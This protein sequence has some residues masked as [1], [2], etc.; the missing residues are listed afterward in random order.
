MTKFLKQQWFLVSLFVVIGLGFWF[1]AELKFLADAKL[2][3][4]CIVAT[5]L[6]LMALPLDTASVRNSIRHPLPALFASVLN[7]G[8][9]PLFAWI[10]VQLL[11]DQDM[12]R[13]LLVTA[14][15]PCT[16]ASAAVWTRRAGGDDAV[17]IL[18]TMITNL[19]CFL[20][21]P[22]WLYVTLGSEISAEDQARLMRMPI[23][24]GLLVVLPMT[25]AQLIRQV[26]SIGVWATKT[27]AAY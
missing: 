5:V 6:F 10:L 15:V 1:P 13:G 7:V 19:T 22:F 4:N 25:L 12:K 23:R 20:T 24:L 11:S 26:P 18:V 21:I 8:L 2:L 27:E 17:S 9:L 14:A 3:R 16:L